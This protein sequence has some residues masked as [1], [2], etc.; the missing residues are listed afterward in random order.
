MQWIQS[1]AHHRRRVTRQR[2][3]QRQVHYTAMV[4]APV[5]IALTT[6]RKRANLP[7]WLAVTIASGA[8]L[9]VAAALPPRSRVR[10][11]AAGMAY[12]WLFKISWELPADD[13]GTHRRRL[14]VDYP[15]RFDSALCGGVPPSAAPAARAAH[16]GR[17]VAARRRRV[18]HLR[19]VVSART[20][21][22]ATRCCA[23]RSTSRAPPAGSPPP[24]T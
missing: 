8:P 1:A 7:P 13:E 19:L 20:C 10:Y 16:E 2:R 6:F 17:G 5:A 23:T 3:L 11:A 18:R 15:I 22:S 12:M 9:A 24:T 14:N 4:Y 21:C